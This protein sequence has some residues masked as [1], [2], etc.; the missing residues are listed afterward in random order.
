MTEPHEMTYDELL[1]AGYQI[2]SWN[3]V[4]K[5]HLATRL[6]VMSPRRQYQVWEITES[7]KWH[8]LATE[9]NF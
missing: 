2:L 1:V 5:L 6:S 7:N 4:G 9:H 3:H 8:V